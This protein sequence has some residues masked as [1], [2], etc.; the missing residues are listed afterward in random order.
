[1]SKYLYTLFLI[2]CTFTSILNAQNDEAVSNSHEQ[3]ISKLIESSV[4]CRDSNKNMSIDICEK[5]IQIAEKEKADSLLALAYKTQGINYYYLREYDSSMIYYDKAVIKFK[6]L[7]NL[8]QA[9]KTLGNIGVV[10]KQKG[11]YSKAIEYYLKEIEIFAEI[12]YISGLASIYLNMGN[13]SVLMNNY[14]RAEEYYNSALKLSLEIDSIGGQ[15]V[16]LS[17]LGV[18]YEKQNEFEKALK[19]YKKSLEIVLNMHNSTMESKLYLNI[20]IIYRRT[21][22][23]DTASLYFK[24][25]FDIRKLRGNY[26]ELLGVHN[27]MFELALATKAYRK[28]EQFIGTM[29]NLAQLNKDSGWLGDTYHAYYKLYKKNG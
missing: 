2:F 1:M 23:F 24:K 7:G 13:I 26:E 27:E 11:K 25:S 15:L 29:E 16:A 9:G 19:A 3:V 12:N 14:Q 17:N 5:A 28:A 21:K 10:Y 4:S 6:E 18:T 8:I 22:A 20:G